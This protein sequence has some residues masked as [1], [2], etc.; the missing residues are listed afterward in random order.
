MWLVHAFAVETSYY[1]NCLCYHTA[2]LARVENYA[3]CC[4]NAMC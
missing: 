2:E 3:E 1:K 4:A